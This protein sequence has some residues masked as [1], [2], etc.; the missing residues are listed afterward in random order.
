MTQLRNW[1][2]TIMAALVLPCA[3][4]AQINRGSITG[5]ATDQSGAVVA[6]VAIAV[7]NEGTGVTTH[8]TTNSSGVY[9][10]PFWSPPAINS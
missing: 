2:I 5:I 8:I 3:A 1:V 6:D 7:T 4:M 9:S 10:L